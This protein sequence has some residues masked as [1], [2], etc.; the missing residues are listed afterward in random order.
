MNVRYVEY[1]FTAL[2]NKNEKPLECSINF[3]T[4]RDHFELSQSALENILNLDLDLSWPFVASSFLNQT[5]QDNQHHCEQINSI[6]KF[7]F[8]SFRFRKYGFAM[9]F[10]NCGKRV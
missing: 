10:L 1:Q 6:F 9:A 2:L 7:S 5:G 3:Q 4:E 8:R